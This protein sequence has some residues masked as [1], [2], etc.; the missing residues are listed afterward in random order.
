MLFIFVFLM[1]FTVWCMVASARLMM[2][3]AKVIWPLLVFLAK[4]LMVGL[5]AVAALIGGALAKREQRG[6][7]DQHGSSAVKPAS[8]D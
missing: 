3:C 6:R 5:V 8:I 2:L 4:M 1:K 7:L